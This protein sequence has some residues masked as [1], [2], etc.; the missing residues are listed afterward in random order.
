MEKLQ[1]FCIYQQN[2]QIPKESKKNDP[3]LKAQCNVTR[4]FIGLSFKQGYGNAMSTLTG[5]FKI[6]D[7]KLIDNLIIIS[8]Q[9]YSWQNQSL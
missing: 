4:D 9:I 3:S 7:S 1:Q 8:S 6:I 5:C 2:Y